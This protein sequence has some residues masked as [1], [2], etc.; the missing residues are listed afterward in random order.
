MRSEHVPPAV[1]AVPAYMEAYFAA[2]AAETSPAVRAVLGHFVLVFIHPYSDG[3]GRVA[4]FLMNLMLA[5]GGYN[6]TVIRVD[7]RQE[8]MAA[9]EQASVH[10]QVEDFTRFIAEELRESAKLKGPRRR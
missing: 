2:L 8:Y 7:R 5:S 4:R 10:G 3:N 6:W 9:L 1:E